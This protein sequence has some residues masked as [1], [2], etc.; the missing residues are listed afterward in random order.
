MAWT[1]NTNI[2]ENRS[3][4]ALKCCDMT[5]EMVWMCVEINGRCWYYALLPAIPSPSISGATILQLSQRCGIFVKRDIFPSAGDFPNGQNKTKIFTPR[6]LDTTSVVLYVLPLP[7]SN[8]DIWFFI[9]GIIWLTRT[10]FCLY[11][12]QIHTCSHLCNKQIPRR[13]N[14]AN[15]IL[16]FLFHYIIIL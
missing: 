5:S 15:V 2:G 11:M 4:Q 3:R 9:Q 10:F 14:P 8:N 16:L 12:V 13:T 6:W 7:A 1:S